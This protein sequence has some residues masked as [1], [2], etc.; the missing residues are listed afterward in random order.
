VNTS[1]LVRPDIA[2]LAEYSPVEPIE[3]Q[4]ARLGLPPEQIAKLDGNEN[5]YGPS[6]RVA[7]AIARQRLELY[8][9]PLHTDLR[10]AVAGYAGAPADRII[11]GNGSDELLELTIRLLLSPGD[12][13]ITCEPTFGMYSFLPPLFLGRIVTVPRRPDFSLDVDATLAAITPRTKLLLLASPNNPTGNLLSPSELA[14]LLQAGPVVLLDEAYVEFSPP[15]SS[16]VPIAADHDNLVILRTF[17]KWAGLAGLRIGYGVFPP[18]LIR[19]L[20][21]IKQPYNV[22]LAAGAAVLASLADRDYLLANV[23]KL[24]AER[25]RMRQ[26]LSVLP[27]WQVYSSDANFLLC[28]MPDARATRDRLYRQGIMVRT[29]FGKAG[30]D[31]CLRISAGKPE[32][33]DRLLQALASPVATEEGTHCNAQSGA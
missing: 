26:A 22:N 9:D 28:R 10:Q 8:P 27:G 31:D 16:A 4:A 32:H 13:V 17:S 3:L 21:K 14:P 18:E 29:Y 23:A 25:T 1:A 24:V 5:P 6:P 7:E 19:H 15:G 2:E 30:L 33:T 12:E 20:W 11:F